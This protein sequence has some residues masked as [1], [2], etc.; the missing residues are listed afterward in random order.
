MA[1]LWFESNP[2]WINPSKFQFMVKCSSFKSCP[3]VIKLP[4]LT[5][6]P[7]NGL[8]WL[9]VSI[10]WSL[11]HT[12]AMSTLCIT[13]EIDGNWL[14]CLWPIILPYSSKAFSCVQYFQ[15]FTW[16]KTIIQTSVNDHFLYE[17]IRRSWT[18]EYSCIELKL[19]QICF[20]CFMWCRPTLS[21]TRICLLNP[22]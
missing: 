1:I 10:C 4:R 22:Y 21:S 14:L 2:M 19:F 9:F 5:E 7:Q 16:R 15:W 13:A 12:W 18:V 11:E 6:K 3:F 17:I 20:I 8:K